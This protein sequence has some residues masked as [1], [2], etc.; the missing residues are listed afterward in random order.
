M[1]GN[2]H[3]RVFQRIFRFP[4]YRHRVGVV[5]LIVAV[6]LAIRACP[7][8]PDGVDLK[9]ITSLRFTAGPEF[10]DGIQRQLGGSAAD[11]S[12]NGVGY[13]VFHPPKS[14]SDPDHRIFRDVNVYREESPVKAQE[15]YADQRQQFTGSDWKLY[16]EKGDAAEKWFISYKGTRF[17]TNHGM[18]VWVN[19]KPEIFIGILKQNVFI[20]VGYTAY[21]SGSDY[22]QTINND[23]RWVAD[24]LSKAARQ[25]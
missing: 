2:L 16:L 22:I 21:A 5:S 7:S 9:P 25:G 18:P 13:L 17:D 20:V 12:K 14:A 11:W 8:K 24:L 6:C 1:D 23:V 3:E 4:L 15:I 19:A 10:L